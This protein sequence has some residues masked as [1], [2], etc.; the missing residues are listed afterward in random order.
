MIKNNGVH[1][2]RKYAGSYHFVPGDLRDHASI[3]DMC[4]AINN[5]YPDGIDILINNAGEMF[6]DFKIK[7][8]FLEENK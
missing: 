1:H 4:G 2:F 7:N 5:I 6:W 3:A 8:I